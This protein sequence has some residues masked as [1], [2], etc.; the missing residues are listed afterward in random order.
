[1][2]NDNRIRWRCRRGMKELDVLME[3]FLQRG[4]AQLD[5]AERESFER[6]LD[7]RDPDLYGWLTGRDLPADR[8]LVSLV[9]RMRP[10]IQYETPR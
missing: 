3:R 7:A 8:A 4:Y 10:L 5:D 1:M 6:L 2:Q 9:E